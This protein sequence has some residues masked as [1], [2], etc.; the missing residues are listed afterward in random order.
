M[1]TTQ[2]IEYLITGIFETQKERISDFMTQLESPIEKLFIIK[3]LDYIIENGF[4]YKIYVYA[5]DEKLVLE[6]SIPDGTGFVIIPQEVFKKYR[7]DFLFLFDK[8]GRLAVECDGHNF[9]EKTKEQAKRDKERDRVFTKHNLPIFR[10]TGSE[11][12][13]DNN[14]ISKEIIDYIGKHLGGVLSLKD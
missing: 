11:I 8:K 6:V 4:G 2:E 10:Y 14:K 7:L 12:F 13:N 9:H 1:D 5:L 3:F